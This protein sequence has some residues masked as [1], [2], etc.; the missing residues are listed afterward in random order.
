MNVKIDRELIGLTGEGLEDF[1]Q[2]IEQDDTWRDVRE[3][4]YTI[5]TVYSDTSQTCLP[6][7]DD[8]PVE[9]F[10]DMEPYTTLGCEAGNRRE[11]DGYK[12]RKR[13]YVPMAGRNVYIKLQNALG[14]PLVEAPAML[15]DP[16]LAYK[17]LRM[18][19][20]GGLFTGYKLE[21]CIN[22]YECNYV[23]ARRVINRLKNTMVIANLA[24]KLELAGVVTDAKRD[25]QQPAQ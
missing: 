16:E 24:Q 7:I 8:R 17:A 5:A 9:D 22:E 11:G 19:M 20:I 18:G 25:Q 10:A 4:C 14:V 2:F 13:G 23:Q 15:E 12:Y 21:D 1:L 3:V 6:S